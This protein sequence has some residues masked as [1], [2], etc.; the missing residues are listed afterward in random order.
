M[1]KWS[2]ISTF[3]SM[4]ILW[5][6]ATGEPEGDPAVPGESLALSESEQEVVQACSVNDDCARGYGCYNGTCF[7][8]V[9]F[10]PVPA[11]PFSPACVSDGQ[12]APAGRR[13]GM[14][15][16]TYTPGGGY[17]YC[18]VPTCSVSWSY[19]PVP[20]GSTV[21][22]NVTSEYMGHGAFSLLYGT[23]NGSWDVY[24]DYYNLVSGVLLV[25]NSPGLSGDYMR[26]VDMYAPDGRWFCRSNYSYVTLQ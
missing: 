24:G 13:C 4:A 20:Q 16:T 1:K 14:H 3:M 7:G 21:N 11:P 12:C 10:G 9:V 18:V 6:C 8:Y 22:F 19:S 17:S 5:G 15:T 25:A 26:F 23:R 2:R